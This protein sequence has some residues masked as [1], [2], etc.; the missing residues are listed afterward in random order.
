MRYPHSHPDERFLSNSQMEPL[1]RIPLRP[2]WEG[3]EVSREKT[4]AKISWFFQF[5]KVWTF[6]FGCHIQ[7][8]SKYWSMKI[9]VNF[10]NS[11]LGGV[12]IFQILKTIS[13]KHFRS[14]PWE[15]RKLTPI[16]MDQYFEYFWMTQRVLRL[17]IDVVTSA[18]IGSLKS[19][20]KY[21]CWWS[22]ELLKVH[23]LVVSKSTQ[24]EYDSKF[25]H[26]YF[27]RILEHFWDF[28]VFLRRHEENFEN[29]L[30]HLRS[31]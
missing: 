6:I 16:F 1:M 29:L 27:D 5:S 23:L 7:K 2:F 20:L 12:K 15:F 31:G 21:I 25:I 22:Q 4:F 18:P 11:Q 17:W 13:Q 19:Y 14:L 9:R 28:H 8:Y 30:E 10:R 24:R 26:L 3:L